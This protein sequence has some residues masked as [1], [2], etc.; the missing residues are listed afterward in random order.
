MK[1]ART[2]T[3]N[4]CK[5]VSLICSA[6]LLS[7]SLVGIKPESARQFRQGAASRPLQADHQ[8]LALRIDTGSSVTV[9]AAAKMQSTMSHQAAR[10]GKRALSGGKLNVRSRSQNQRPSRTSISTVALIGGGG[11][12][13]GGAQGGRGGRGGGLIMPGGGRGPA[14]QEGPGAG[15]HRSVAAAPWRRR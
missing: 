4:D 9:T 6:S 3:H 1:V 5:S 8:G 13:G 10:F 11:R 2:L 15:H 12:G 14:R 7:S